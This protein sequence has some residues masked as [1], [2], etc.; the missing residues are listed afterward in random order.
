MADYWDAETGEELD[1]DNLAERYRMILDDVYGEV[2]IAGMTF[3]SSSALEELDPIAF[4]CG[5][6]DYIDSLMTDGEITDEE[7]DDEE[8]EEDDDDE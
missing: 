7:P 4:R 5:V 3:Y 8:E 2:D 1:W 6:N